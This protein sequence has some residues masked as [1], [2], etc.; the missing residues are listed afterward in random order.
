M[1][2]TE[3]YKITPVSRLNVI[4]MIILNNKATY[5]CVVVGDLGVG[6]TM[7]L[8]SF[9]TQEFPEEYIPPCVPEV[10]ASI[11]FTKAMIYLNY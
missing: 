5:K 11:V 9:A 6:K 10:V 3:I 1:Y 4:I 2:A 7:L 8:A